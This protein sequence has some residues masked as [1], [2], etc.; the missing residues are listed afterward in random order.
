MTC[1]INNKVIPQ[2]VGGDIGCGISCYDL[3]KNIKEKQYA[4]YDNLVKSLIPMGEKNHKTPIINDEIMNKLY[5]KCNIKLENLKQKFPDYPFNEFSYNDNYY[6]RLIQR[7]KSN[8]SSNNYLRSIGTLGGGNH[9]IEFNK[10]E[11]G[12]CYLTVHS[13][14][15]QIGQAI[16]NYHQNKIKNNN[17]FNKKDFFNHYI[18]NEDLVEY[19]IDMLFAQQFASLNRSVII[20]R[21]CK[22]IGVQFD[23]RKMI[24]S[25]HNYIDFDRLILRKGAISAEANKLCII[26]L[27]MRDGIL[28]CKGKGNPEW[29]YSSAHGCGRL[30]S[31]RDARINFNMKDY[32]DSMK[33]IYSSSV[34]K[35][36]LDE[37]PE[38]Y[39]E[40]ELIKKHIGQSVDIIKQLFPIIN[41]KGY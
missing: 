1:Q 35:Q 26:S 36:T 34:C 16:C 12:N 4:K 20:E 7:A 13:G 40:V 8:V 32:R 33:D 14:S 9:Y 25:V 6:K 41:I 28:I 3:N 30:M 2:I 24:E 38:A 37:I 10:E 39:K 31:R 27:N 29:N 18:E 5:D 21:I 11:N 22:N 23:S 19:L 17:K 15:R